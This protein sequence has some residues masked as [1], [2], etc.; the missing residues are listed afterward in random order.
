VDRR[1]KG[2]AVAV[3]PPMLLQDFTSMEVTPPSVKRKKRGKP[4]RL[5]V[6]TS[7]LNIWDKLGKTDSGLSLLD[8][9]AI[10]KDAGRDLTDGL[11]DLRIQRP[12]RTKR[13]L[14]GMNM[15]SGGVNDPMVVNVVD[16][17]EGAYDSGGDSSN[18]DSDY[19]EI[20]TVES[21]YI[22]DSDLEFSDV[23]SVYRYPYNLN[24]MK[25][26]SPMRGV[27]EICG[28]PVVACFDSGASI[29][30]ISKKLADSLGLVPNGDSLNL[31]GFDNK[32]ATS[33]SEIVMDVPVKVA[34]KLRPDHMCIQDGGDD[35]LCLLGVPWFQAYGI[36]LNLVDSTI[37]IPSTKGM[38]K[39]QGFTTHIPIVPEV[40]VTSK[41][42]YMID[43]SQKYTES[44]EESLVPDGREKDEI[45][46]EV[47]F[48]SDNISTGVPEELVGVIE[49]YKHCF[50]EVSGLTMI[51]GHAMK[52]TLKDGAVPVR[53]RPFR[54]SW[55]DE[56]IL[57]Q[58]L[59]EMLELGLIEPSNGVWTSPCFLV[60]KKDGT[61]RVVIDYR[62]ANTMI[63]QTN[64]PT[65]TIAELTEATRQMLAI[66]HLAIVPAVIIS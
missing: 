4:R 27:I 33:R 42:V 29:S 5:S 44:L 13:H 57:N 1:D 49:E 63:V 40:P 6:K 20:S 30:V 7:R 64:F 14:A 66:I 2:K 31:V 11:R 9:I 50:S 32:K 47:S 38:V 56:D 36:E 62:K 46:E 41:Q 43:A 12:K 34:G 18:Y 51:K 21:D 58:Y 54:L 16:Q 55:E 39:L 24:R 26:S 48:N 8:W 45:V 19:S 3:A 52:I 35:K 60:P 53:T 28:K 22:D 37:R 17:D 23:E 59:D 10:D 25:I 65:C 61:K 15:A